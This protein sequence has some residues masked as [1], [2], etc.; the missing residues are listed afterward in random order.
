MLQDQQAVCCW[1]HAVTTSQQL[2][3]STKKVIDTK[4][5]QSH[6]HISA[7][8]HGWHLD[9]TGHTI[10]PLVQCNT[11]TSAA[12]LTVHQLSTLALML[13]QVRR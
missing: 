5:T 12:P 8:D 4:H 11:H 13:Q 3:S 9:I 10:E 6:A 7:S 1:Q 2:H